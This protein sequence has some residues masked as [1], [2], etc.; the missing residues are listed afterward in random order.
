MGS[1]HLKEK[2]ACGRCFILRSRMLMGLLRSGSD[3]K[4]VKSFKHIQR[5][6]IPRSRKPKSVESEFR[7]RSTTKLDG[8]LR[9]ST[10][11]I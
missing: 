10:L 9:K 8:A 6:R 11:Y 2:Q 1:A 4:G 7:K 5:N 3:V